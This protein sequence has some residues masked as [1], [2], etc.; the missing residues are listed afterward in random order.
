MG[1]L[2]DIQNEQGTAKHG[3]H[4]MVCK[5]LEIMS[6][7]DSADLA[8]ALDDHSLYGTVIA[9]TLKKSGY[10]ISHYQIQRHRRRECAKK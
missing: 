7:K 10:D 3:P 2:D 1:L 9:R 8:T 4:C 6:P 5:T